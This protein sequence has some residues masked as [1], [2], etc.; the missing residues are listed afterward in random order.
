MTTGAPADGRSAWLRP[1]PGDRLLHALLVFS[2]AVAAYLPAV[3]NDFAYDDLPIVALDE[4]VRTFDVPAILTGGYWQDTASVLYR[5]ATTLSYALDWKISDGTPGWS[6]AVNMMW[7]GV[8]SVLVLLLLRAFRVPPAAA[9]V[10]AAVFAVHPVHVEAV[11]NIVGRAELMAAA[12]TLAAALLFTLPARTLRTAAA[13]TLLLTLFALALLSKESAVM[14]PALLVLTD[15]GT[16][17]LRPGRVRAWLRVRLPSLLG[18][19][20]VL[21]LYF[22]TRH[23]VLGAMTPGDLDPS[24]EVLDSPLHRI[25]TALQAW[26]QYARLLFYP[27]VL[28]AD[29]GPRIMLPATQLNAAA[30]L[31]AGL[32][33]LCIG[34]G[35]A[36]WRRRDP[37]AAAALLWFPV[38]LLPAS[39]LLIPIGVLIAE[40]TLYL[41]SIALPMGIA[42]AAIRMYGGFTPAR[43]VRRLATAALIGLTLGLLTAR[44]LIRIPDWRNTNTVFFALLQDRPD[45]FRGVWHAAR[46]AASHGSPDTAMRLHTEAIRLWPYRPRLLREA[47]IYAAAN[48]RPDWS[49]Q[50]AEFGLAHVPDDLVVRRF[51]AGTLL[52]GGDTA[53]A[54]A[55]I[56]EGLKWHP[57]DSLL[58]MMLDAATP[59]PTRNPESGS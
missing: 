54:R 21:A 17:R 45:A 18:L 10:A 31:G 51:H 16:R 38:A 41:P 44:T 2:L 19:A 29:Y 12:F 59:P 8:V 55:Q 14:L 47:V 4:R 43:P 6:H 52:D 56:T 1:L 15:A 22:G 3:S 34:G 32:I 28:L 40:R 26:P 9:L 37:L 57:Q 20:A 35:M 5:P 42:A 30:L 48:G 49:R 25:Y 13:L 24:L 46:L 33:T 27:R 58:L 7:H 36:A 50:L 39:N 53:A 23:V 11:A